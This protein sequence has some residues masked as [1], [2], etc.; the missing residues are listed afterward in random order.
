M[1]SL[2]IIKILLSHLSKSSVEYIDK[3]MVCSFAMFHPTSG[4]FGS[5]SGVVMC[6]VALLAMAGAKLQHAQRNLALG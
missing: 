1:Q 2:Y 4:W 5:R 6:C 3:R